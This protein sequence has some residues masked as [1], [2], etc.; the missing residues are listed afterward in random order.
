MVCTQILPCHQTGGEKCTGAYLLAERLAY[1]IEGRNSVPVH[2][3]HAQAIGVSLCAHRLVE[4]GQS[5]EDG[6]P[7]SAA[8]DDQHSHLAPQQFAV[9]FMCIHSNPR[10]SLTIPATTTG[11]GINL[12][13]DPLPSLPPF[14]IHG[15]LRTR[16]VIMG[17]MKHLSLELL[18][19]Y[20]MEDISSRD[21]QRVERH[22]DALP[23]VL[24]DRLHGEVGWASGS[25]DRG[26]NQ[27]KVQKPS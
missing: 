5:S 6:T 16:R 24:L 4:V 20:V 9:Q 27:E 23:V 2:D 25:A 17:S 13:L 7:C 18:E 14:L 12:R 26:Q 21:Q 10:R 11:A 8:P 1:T 3:G 19:R 15:R 22:G